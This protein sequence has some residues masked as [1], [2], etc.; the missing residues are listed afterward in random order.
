MSG[1]DI[2]PRQL[3]PAQE[4]KVLFSIGMIFAL[5]LVFYLIPDRWRNAF[6]GAI[7]PVILAMNQ[8]YFSG[9][10][11]WDMLVIALALFAWAFMLVRALRGDDI[12]YSWSDAIGA[13]SGLISGGL[14]WQQWHDKAFFAAW[15]TAIAAAPTVWAIKKLGDGMKRTAA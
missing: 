13:L 10:N 3:T 8:P 9:L 5:L 14:F 7:R 1:D 4:N 6:G 2:A 15:C 11:G 12:S